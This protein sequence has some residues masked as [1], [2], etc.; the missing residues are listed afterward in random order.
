MAIGVHCRRTIQLLVTQRTFLEFSLNLRSGTPAWRAWWSVF[1]SAEAAS[2]VDGC[3]LCPGTG[4]PQG[5]IVRALADTKIQG[6]G[7]YGGAAAAWVL[8]QR[9]MA[10]PWIVVAPAWPAS[11]RFRGTTRWSCC[12]AAAVTKIQG[13]GLSMSRQSALCEDSGE[14]TGRPVSAWSRARRFRGKTRSGCR[15]N[16][17]PAKIQGSGTITSLQ[18][19]R[20]HED[21][22]ESA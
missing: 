3:C 19:R 15:Q 16:T 1:V 17:R 2:R 13:N 21:S 22:G 5:T 9:L 12:S 10:Q 18:Q 7:Q 14:K 8:P 11:R 20:C 4:G 6:N